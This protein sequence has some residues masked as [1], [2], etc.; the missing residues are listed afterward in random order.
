VHKDDCRL[1]WEWANEPAVREASFSSEPI[2]WKKH[3]KWFRTKLKDPLCLFFIALNEDCEPIGQVRYD[4]DDKEAVI[5]VSL[6]KEIRGKGYGS[7]LIR[8]A[9]ERVLDSSEV[10]EI[11]A[12]IK[13][14][15]K[16][17]IHAFVKAGFQEFGT[18]TIHGRKAIKFTVKQEAP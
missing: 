8:L 16:A 14:E 2:P 11:H 5:S 12:Y 6:A 10:N 17:S 4:I 7:Q 18:S 15:N 1:L 3:A 9:S 13:Q